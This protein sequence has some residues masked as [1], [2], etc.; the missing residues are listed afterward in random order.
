MFAVKIRM[1]IS[2][3]KTSSD[4][5]SVNW[6]YFKIRFSGSSLEI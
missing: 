4:V 1:W 2:K 5:G 3:K 6:S